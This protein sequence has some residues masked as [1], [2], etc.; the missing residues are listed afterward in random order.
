MSILLII[1]TQVSHSLSK[2]DLL[3][4]PQSKVKACSPASTTPSF[5]STSLGPWPRIQL[6]YTSFDGRS[7]SNLT[8][9]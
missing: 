3:L 5:L 4:L 2:S 8:L 6:T 7:P 1:D 9:H